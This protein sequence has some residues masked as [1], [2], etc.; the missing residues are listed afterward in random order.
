MR[1]KPFTATARGILSNIMGVGKSFWQKTL[2]RIPTVI[3]IFQG[4]QKQWIINN[5]ETTEDLHRYTLAEVLFMIFAFLFSLFYLV[6]WVSR[7]FEDK[8]I[9]E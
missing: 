2:T 1:R 4:K 3:R 9:L 7:K 8:C 6:M 5:L